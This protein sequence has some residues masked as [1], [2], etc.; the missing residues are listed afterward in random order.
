MLKKTKKVI[1]NVR[2]ASKNLHIKH[3]A[4]DHKKCFV[5]KNFDLNI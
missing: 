1:K 3:Y 2:G 4:V 5:E